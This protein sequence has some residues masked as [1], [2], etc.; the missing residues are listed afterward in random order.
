[1]LP[2]LFYRL[3][4]SFSVRKEVA[5]RGFANG[6][7]RTAS[8]LSVNPFWRNLEPRGEL[9]HRQT[10]RHYRPTRPLSLCFSTM[11]KANIPNCA[12]KNFCNS[13]C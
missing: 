6:S 12:W 11:S 4:S 10:T 2:Q 7:K 8:Q 9:R 3:Q 5:S 13:P 1:M